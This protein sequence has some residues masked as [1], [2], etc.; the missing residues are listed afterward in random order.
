MLAGLCH[1][2]LFCGSQNILGSWICPSAL[3]QCFWGFSSLI[4]RQ[5]LYLYLYECTCQYSQWLEEGMGG[6]RAGFTWALGTEPGSSRKAAV[7]LTSEPL[8][9]PL[10]F[11]FCFCLFVCFEIGFLCVALDVLELILLTRL[12]SNSRNPPASTSGLLGACTTT[13]LNLAR[14]T[15]VLYNVWQRIL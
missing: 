3:L 2:A 6:K 9:Q 11:C 8:L 7:L 4:F 13:Y 12:P 5:V 1:L 14:M 10:F 15:G